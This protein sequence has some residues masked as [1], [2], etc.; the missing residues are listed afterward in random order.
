MFFPVFQETVVFLHKA[1]CILLFLIPTCCHKT[2]VPVPVCQNAYP[3]RLTGYFR[4]I[5][6]ISHPE[7]GLPGNEGKKQINASL[8]LV[9]IQQ[10]VATADIIPGCIG[11]GTTREG[12]GERT[13]R[14]TGA[15][16]ADVERNS[17]AHIAI[18]YGYGIPAG[19]ASYQGSGTAAY[20]RVPARTT[21]GVYIGYIIE[22]H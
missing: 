4:G 6:K 9:Q 3:A 15:C 22:C 17:A 19:T 21:W 14:S 10:H 2:Q 16:A 8:N 11:Q 5:V 7:G 13:D 12:T 18:I 1:S 20:R